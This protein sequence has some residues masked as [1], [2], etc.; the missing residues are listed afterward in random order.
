MIDS[1][2]ALRSVYP[3]ARPR[4][5]AKQL[6]HLDTHCRRYIALSPFLVLATVGADGRVDASPRGGEPG[7]FA[8]WTSTYFG[9]QTRPAKI[10]GSI[11]LRNIAQTG[12]T[13]GLLFFLPAWTKPCASMA[14]HSCETTRKCSRNFHH[15]GILPAWCSRSSSR[16]PICIAPRRSMPI[17]ALERRASRRPS[18]VPVDGADDQ[19]ASGSASPRK[20][21]NRCWCVTARSFSALSDPTKYTS[22]SAACM[23]RMPMDRIWRS[24]A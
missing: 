3:A 10:I 12:V 5:V 20:R 1:A 13:R 9:F 7:L 6:D 17:Q 21:R 22:E 2:E 15:S 23:C 19:G 24:F 14:A 11:P 16:K 4:A 18:Q 8:C